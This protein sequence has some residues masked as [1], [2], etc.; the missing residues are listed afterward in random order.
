MSMVL[1][2]DKISIQNNQTVSHLLQY[3]SKVIHKFLSSLYLIILSIVSGKRWARFD[4]E[5]PV[6]R[7]VQGQERA[8]SWLLEIVDKFKARAGAISKMWQ[9]NL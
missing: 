8:I 7:V 3:L 2:L 6:L 4:V 5:I 9:S 1:L